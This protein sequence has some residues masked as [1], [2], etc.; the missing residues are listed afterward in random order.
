M[1]SGFVPPLSK[2]VMKSSWANEGPRNRLC[3]QPL[4]L[5]QAA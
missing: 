4:G 5:L 2:T 1:K 3:L